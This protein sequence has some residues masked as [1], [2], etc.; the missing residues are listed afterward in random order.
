MILR[1][2]TPADVTDRYVAWLNDPEV[3]RFLETRWSVQSLETVERYVATKAAS[4]T[5]HLFGIFLDGPRHIG[6]IKIGPINRNHLTADVSYFLGERS[7]WGR[8]YGTEAVSAACRMA[9]ANFGLKKLSAGVYASN[10]ASITVLQRNG[11]QL[12]GVRV[13]HSVLDGRRV[14]LHEFGLLNR[15]VQADGSR[16]D[17]AS[18]DIAVGR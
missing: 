6:N 2:L 12:E 13:A 8:G 15:K 4:E 5:E 14:D 1:R 18:M 7:V 9:F 3:N 10:I 11:F 17:E 16:E